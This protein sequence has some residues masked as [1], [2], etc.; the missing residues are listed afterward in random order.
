MLRRLNRK[1]RRI[2]DA[3]DRIHALDLESLSQQQQRVIA[4]Q[5]AAFR[6]QKV[7]PYEDIRDAGFRVYSQYEEDGIILYVLSMIGFRTRKVVEMCIADGR[8]CMATN[9]ILNHGFEG[10]L[11][12]GNEARIR[13]ARKFFAG[14]QDTLLRQP[15]VRHAWITAENVNDL[16]TDAGAFGEVDLFSL[17]IDGNDYWVWKAIEVIRPRLLVLETHAPIP[18]DLS[19]TIRYRPDFYCWDKPE[20]DY[21]SVSLKAMTKLCAAKGYRLIGAHKHGFNAF[22]LRNDEGEDVFPEVSV[23]SVHDNTVTRLAQA[24][25]WPRVKHMDW[26]EV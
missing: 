8:E 21:R 23:E 1:L 16:L 24:E 17:D 5:Y 22:Y 19:L 6:Q 4:N 20:P 25:R 15:A 7:R 18:S 26:V 13:G 11:F 10:Y 3:V 9:L 12:D 2:F 14:K